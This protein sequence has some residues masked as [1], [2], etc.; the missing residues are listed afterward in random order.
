MFAFSQLPADRPRLMG[1]VNI[2]PNSFSD[3]GAFLEPGLAADYARQLA[4]QGAAIVDLGP[5]ASSFFRPGVAPVP[6]GEQTRRLLP[7]LALLRNLPPHV[8]ISI[9]TRSS[10]VADAAL[11]TLHGRAIINDISA[12]THDPELLP[13]VARYHAAV[14]LMHISP[15]YPDTPAA[16]DP[17]ILATVRTY[18]E[19][20]AQAALAAGIAPESIA[21]DPGLGFGKT[22]P[23]NWRLA[24]R[25]G[26]ISSRFP[27][28]LGA[29]R[30]RFLDTAPPPDAPLPSDWNTR[31][32]SLRTGFDALVRHPRDLATAALTQLTN[33]T[34]IHRVHNVALAHG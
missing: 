1:I 22:M 34:A 8:V 20:R 21:L 28:V 26:E 14:I 5:E 24:L 12:G 25:A 32:E 27:L 6:P 18:L 4:A 30:K 13:T 31:I 17:H 23:D 3:A 10:I 33:P 16:D 19:A 2:T 29:S 15:N 7:V 11:D 9:D